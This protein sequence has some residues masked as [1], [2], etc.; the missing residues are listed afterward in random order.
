MNYIKRIQKNQDDLYRIL[1]FVKKDFLLIASACCLCQKNN[2]GLSRAVG[3][4]AIL[5]TERNIAIWLSPKLSRFFDR[6]I[7]LM[8]R[9]A[10]IP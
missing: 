1:K 5:K 7:L 6:H 8:R 4:S 9:A 10:K 3:S 2:T